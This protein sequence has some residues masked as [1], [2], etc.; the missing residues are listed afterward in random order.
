MNIADRLHG[1]AISSVAC[2]QPFQVGVALIKHRSMFYIHVSLRT[3]SSTII[4]KTPLDSIDIYAPSN[5]H[6]SDITLSDEV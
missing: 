2:I 6:M 1:I 4:Y 3:L 5:I